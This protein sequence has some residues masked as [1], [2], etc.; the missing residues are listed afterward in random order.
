MTDINRIIDEM[1]HE[2]YE[3]MR[4]AVELG[5]WE[6]G[7]VL[8]EEQRDNTLQVV[9]LYQAR[10]MQQDQHLTIG[11]NGVFNDLSKLE[12]K[13]RMARDFGGESIAIFGNDEI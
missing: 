3:R 10:R 1:P 7:S 5:K 4:S 2:V 6:D 8:S 13:K 12:L 9:M 11:A